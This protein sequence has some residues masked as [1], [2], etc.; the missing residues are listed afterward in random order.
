[1]VESIMPILQPMGLDEDPRA[2]PGWWKQQTWHDNRV[3][4]SV[5]AA[6]VVLGF[7]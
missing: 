6:V 3:K 2:G 4:L 7:G 5:A 1:M